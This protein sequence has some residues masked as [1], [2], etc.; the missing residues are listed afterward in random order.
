MWHPAEASPEAIQAVGILH[1]DVKPSNFLIDPAGRVHLTDFGLAR[2][3]DES[4][5]TLAGETFGSPGFMAPE[6][7]GPAADDRRPDRRLRPRARRSTRAL[8][9]RLPYGR[10]NLARRVASPPWSA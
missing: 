6:Q 10:T 3:V 5:L 1:R 4:G 9:G 2:R 8:T 7:P